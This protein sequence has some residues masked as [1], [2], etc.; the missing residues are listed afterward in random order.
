MNALARPE[1]LSLTVTRLFDAPRDLVWACFTRHDMLMAWWGPVPHPACVVDM[2]IRVGGR[3]RNCLQ[4]P[5]GSETLWQN[6]VYTEVTPPSRLV[7]TFRWEDGE[8][9]DSNEVTIDFDDLGDKTRLTLTQ[10]PFGTVTSRDGHGFGWNS[11]FDRLAD[12]LT[13]KD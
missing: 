5:D 12:Y 2:D 6:G 7:F 3:W 9:G 13:A 4:S 8:G 1:T 11:S 10:T